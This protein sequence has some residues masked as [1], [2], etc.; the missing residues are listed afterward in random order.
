MSMLASLLLFFIR[1]DFILFFVLFRSGVTQSSR[2]GLEVDKKLCVRGVLAE[3]IFALG[4]CA[5]TGCAPTAQSASQQGKYL[6][7]LFRD[8]KL[9]GQAVLA[10][11]EFKFVNKG[12]L[13]YLGDGKG[14]CRTYLTSPHF[15]SSHLLQ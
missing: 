8:T 3:N 10:Y 7:R 6:G 5:V 11:P 12:S 1:F 15:L 14:G 13:A 2:W 4:D 9:E